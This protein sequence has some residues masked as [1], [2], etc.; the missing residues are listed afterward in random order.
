MDTHELPDHGENVL[1]VAISDIL[2]TN[3]NRTDTKSLHSCNS[4]ITV[5]VL[6]EHVLR[7]HVGLRPVDT[8]IIDTV[9]NTEDNKTIP[10]FFVQIFDKAILDLHGVDPETEGTL[11]TTSL[12][13]IIDEASS[14]ELLLSKFLQTVLGVEDSSDED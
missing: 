2:G 6:M 8:G 7:G 9:A 14:F 11:F 4:Q 5:V 12:D 10:H 13:V 1:L 3:S